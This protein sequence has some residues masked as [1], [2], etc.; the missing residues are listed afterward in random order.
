[1][2]FKERIWMSIWL[3]AIKQALEAQLRQ[4]MVRTERLAAT[5][6]RDGMLAEVPCQAV[7]LAPN[8]LSAYCTMQ[9]IARLLDQPDTLEYWKSA[10]YL[11]NFME[12]YQ[13]KQAFRAAIGTP[14]LDNALA[15]ALKAADGLLLPQAEIA[16]YRAIDPGNARL[17]DLLAATIEPGAWRLLWIPPALPYYRLDGPFADPSLSGF[18]KRLVFSSWRVVPKIIAILLSYEA[19]RQMICSFEEAPENS[20]EARKRRSR[21]LRFARVDGHPTGMPVLSLIYPSP[22]LAQLG[23]PLALVAGTTN[24]APPPATPC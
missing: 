15:Q 7:R 1:M 9:T 5:A 20:P 21:L 19:E 8:D 12:G 6:D 18:T 22:V 17:R 14:D 2:L 10:P 16:T 23:D 13:I 4:V 24:T 3:R 11:L